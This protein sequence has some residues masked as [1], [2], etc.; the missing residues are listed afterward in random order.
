MTNEMVASLLAEVDIDASLAWPTRFLIV[1]DAAST[2]RFIRTVLECCPTFEVA[3]EADNGSTA[4]SMAQDLQPDVVLL[5]LSMPVT[6]GVAELTDV[7]RAA[8]EAL[9]I[10]LS[11]TDPQGA[12]A[13]LAAG[14]TAFIPK[15]LPPFALLEQL[16]SILERHVT[17]PAQGSAADVAPPLAPPP[18]PDGRGRA[19][20][21][22]DDAV[23]RRLIGGVVAGCGMA[24]I[25]DSDS[26]QDLLAVIALTHPDLV[27][28]D[29][30][31]DGTTGTTAIPEIHR[32][33]PGT[34]VVVYSAQDGWQPGALEAGAA[35]FV[36]KPD[37]DGLE[38]EV[39]RLQAA[40]V[41]LTGPDTR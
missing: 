21:C 22:D 17:E 19:I 25:A 40:T 18:G 31:L 5:D 23:S 20:V 6:D 13:L 30:W 26:V 36:A 8:P 29:R 41:A 33:S 37:L 35:S 34:V 4:A 14:A 9:V 7:L 12:P 2:R 27:I 16:G 38:V 32:V 1:D 28:L 10:V 39:R 24:V 3:G 15:D 11:G